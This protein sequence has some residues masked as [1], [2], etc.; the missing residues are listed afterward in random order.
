VLEVVRIVQI[1]GNYC[2]PNW[3]H[4][5]PVP[6]SDYDRYP[7]VRPIDA[8][9]RAC[10]AHD[11]DCSRGGCSRRGDKRLRNAALMIAGTTR[12]PIIRNKALLIA[13]GM[14]VTSTRRNR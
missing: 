13:A 2:G 10:Q 9:D 14:T 1:H 7:E 11:K 8:L 6:A 5:L 3:T 4:G 12:N